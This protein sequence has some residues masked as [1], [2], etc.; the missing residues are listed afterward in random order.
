MN[1][2]ISQHDN[3]LASWIILRVARKGA[4]KT[5]LRIETDLILNAEDTTIKRMPSMALQQQ[6]S[7]TLANIDTLI[8]SRLNRSGKAALTSRALDTDQAQR[9]EATRRPVPRGRSIV[10][11]TLF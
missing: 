11:R 7:H 2:D 5:V 6:Q 1:Q 9:R 4:I 10:C 3:A 8:A